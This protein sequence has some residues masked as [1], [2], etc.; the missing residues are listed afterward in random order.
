VNSVE[1]QNGEGIG[2]MAAAL[3]HAVPRNDWV[4]VEAV[5][6]GAVWLRASECH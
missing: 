6:V 3:L 5:C 2:E 1:R 4:E